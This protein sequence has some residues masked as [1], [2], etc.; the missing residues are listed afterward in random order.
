MNRSW[1]IRLPGLL[2]HHHKLEA[3]KAIRAAGLPLSLN[4]VLH[5]G[6]IDR[7]PKIVDFARS[8]GASRLELANTQYIRWATQPHPI[9]PHRE[10]VEAALRAAQ[11]AKQ[12]ILR[13]DGH[14]CYVLPDYYEERPKPCIGR[15]GRC[16][17]TVSPTGQVLPYPTASNIPGLRFGMFAS[18][19]GLDLARV[20]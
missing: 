7:L 2:A 19:P 12:Q 14:F 18:A 1:P 6:N 16:Y 20:G 8:V 5:R 15:L 4:V 3:A 13:H 9:A 17:L 10:Q 11:A